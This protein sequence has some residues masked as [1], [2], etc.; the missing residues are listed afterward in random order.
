MDTSE[1]AGPPDPDAGPRQR[2]PRQARRRLLE[3]GAAVFAEA[4]YAGARVDAI[5]ARAGLNKRM[6]YHYFGD[7]AGLY[8][9]VLDDRLGSLREPA[10]AAEGFGDLEA[11]VA[12]LDTTLARLLLWNLLHPGA[13]ESATL[14]TGV[15]GELPAAEALGRALS[16]LPSG[17]SA[18]SLAPMLMAFLVVSRARGDD[19]GVEGDALMLQVRQLVDVLVQGPGSPPVKPRIRF[20]PDRGG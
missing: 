13:P 20:K 14:D 7:K 18:A 8:R 6:L 12:R 4:G 11:F 2:D 9:A 1:Q 16:M 15:S 3:A 19:A 17:R 5:A 10:S